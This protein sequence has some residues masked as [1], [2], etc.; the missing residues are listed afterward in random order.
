MLGVVDVCPNGA[1]ARGGACWLNVLSGAKGS[2][3]GGRFC[4][5]GANAGEPHLSAGWEEL[6]DCEK[7]CGGWALQAV[8]VF[9][10]G[11]AVGGHNQHNP[12]L[13]R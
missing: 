11:V 12:V 13:Q 6:T 9:D 1:N 7:E 2:S 3:G 4:P 10:G 5:G 8:G